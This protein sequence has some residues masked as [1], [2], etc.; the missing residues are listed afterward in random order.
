MTVL[1]TGGAGYIG[2]HIVRALQQRAEHVV[3]ADN[4]QSG[5][6]GRIGDATLV[7]IDLTGPAS[8][9]ALSEVLNAY[10]VTAVV[11]MAAL[12]RADESVG[13]PLKYY[14]ENISML[15]NVLRAMDGTAAD[16]FVFSSS[17]AVYGNPPEDRVTEL[18]PAMPINPYGSSKLAGEWLVRDVARASGIRAVSLRYFNVAGAGAHDL[19]DPVPMNLVTR[20]IDALERG[21]VP[22]IFG[23]DYPT[24]DGT[25]VRDYVH[26]EDLAN[27]HI[28]ALVYLEHG[29]RYSVFNV[30]TGEGAS[31]REVLRELRDVSGDDFE[32]QIAARRPGD[33]ASVVADASMIRE[34]FDWAPQHDLRSMIASAWA[35]SQHPAS[36]HPVSSKVES[37]TSAPNKESRPS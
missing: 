15:A 10:D 21:T 13:S 2:S 9:S 34:H 36:L 24:P 4:L 14:R 7:Q 35:A 16:K 12:K 26:V 37:D 23:D 5:D 1:V 25:G 29:Q 11:H 19:A 18:T 3:V 22:Q 6:A 27:A 8:A 32:P 20:A 31:V 17:A 28:A 30:G 33:P